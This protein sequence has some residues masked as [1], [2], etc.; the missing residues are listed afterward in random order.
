MAARSAC[1]A[2]SAER[3]RFAER[4]ARIIF[5]RTAESGF[6]PPQAI[7]NGPACDSQSMVSGMTPVSLQSSWKE[8]RSTLALSRASSGVVPSAK[9]PPR[10]ISPARRQ[11]T[12]KVLQVQALPFC[13]QGQRIKPLGLLVKCTCAEAERGGVARSAPK[14]RVQRHGR[15]ERKERAYMLYS[16]LYL[17]SCISDVLNLFSED[18]PLSNGRLRQEVL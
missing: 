10:P 11:S 13:A 7:Q 6:A 2:A 16:P 17:T 14:T 15:A 8:S 1:A 12:M 18:G 5:W 4:F 9:L 3:A